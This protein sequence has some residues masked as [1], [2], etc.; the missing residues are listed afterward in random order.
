VAGEQ[1]LGETAVPIRGTQS[2]VHTLSRCWFRPSL[3]GLEVLW[4][5]TFGLPALLIVW[6]QVRRI[7]LAH[8]GGTMDFGRLGIDQKMITDPV[9]TAAADPLGITAKVGNAV[10]IVLPDLLHVATWLVPVLLVAWIVIASVG[11]TVMLR[12]MDPT[13]H[14]RVGTLMVLQTLRT[15]ALVAVF[16]AWFACLRG[17]VSVAITQ[18]VAAG[19]E[20]NLV[21]YFA[22]MIVATLGLFTGWA[23]VSWALAV[24]PLLAMLRDVGA[25]GALSSAFKLGPLKSKLIEVNLVMGIVKISLIVLAMVFSACPLPFQSVTSDDFLRNWWI[26]VTLLYLVGSDFF[27]V[28]RLMAYLELWR[29]YED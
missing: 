29:V 1:G 11:R 16:G 18:P 7:L 28:A 12:R 9:G 21:L 4:R 27:H 6:S 20:P 13:L 10:G 8:M 19:N 25:G 3:I 17:T 2:L 14:V 23:V 24:S 5:W 26:G 22:L 15:V